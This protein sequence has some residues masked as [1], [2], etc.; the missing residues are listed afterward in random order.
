MKLQRTHNRIQ[1]RQNIQHQDNYMKTMKTKM[2]T[3]GP[4]HTE[5]EELTIHKYERCFESYSRCI[6][7]RKQQHFFFTIIKHIYIYM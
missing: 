3:T 5:V 4:K 1:Q 2:T 7:A 6:K